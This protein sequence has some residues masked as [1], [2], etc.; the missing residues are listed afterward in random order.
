[1]K[2]S[3]LSRIG[4]I[5]TSIGLLLTAFKPFESPKYDTL[6]AGILIGAGLGFSISHFIMNRA[7]KNNSEGY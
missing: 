4:A 7:I 1:M 3:I 5:C 2:P 6:L